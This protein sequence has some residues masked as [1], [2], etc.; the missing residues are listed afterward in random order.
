MNWAGSWGWGWGRE[1]GRRGRPSFA[2]IG[3]E[4]SSQLRENRLSCWTLL[5]ALPLGRQWVKWGDAW[6]HPLVCEERML[7]KWCQE[8][9]LFLFITNS[10]KKVNARE[11][12]FNGEKET[13]QPGAQA[14]FLKASLSVP[15]RLVPSAPAS[16][17]WS[18]SLSYEAQNLLRTEECNTYFWKSQWWVGMWPDVPHRSFIIPCSLLLLCKVPLGQLVQAGSSAP[19][20]PPGNWQFDLEWPW[21]VV[22]VGFQEVGEFC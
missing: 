20:L 13:T 8:A 18:I 17:C 9:S 7:G 15:V 21:G 16:C 19:Q 22:V 4:V 5:P 1:L 2:F 12:A 14:Q 6:G 3:G 10:F 11:G